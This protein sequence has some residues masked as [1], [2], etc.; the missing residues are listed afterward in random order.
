MQGGLCA[1]GGVFAGT[2]RY[3]STEPLICVGFVG[4][5][6]MQMNVTK[7]TSKM[8]QL[9][10]LCNPTF[11]PHQIQRLFEAMNLG[12]YKETV[13]REC[14]DGEILSELDERSLESDLGISSKIHRIRLMQIITG[15]R[16]A[17]TF[18]T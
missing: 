4:N 14:I 6:I 18:L 7:F 16:S 10:Y 2:L 3:M 8:V 9:R 5:I 17:K 13:A 12:K 1:R 15:S 11:C